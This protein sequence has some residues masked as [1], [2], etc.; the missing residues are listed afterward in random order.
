MFGHSKPIPFNPYGSRRARRRFPPWLALLVLGIAA[1]VGGVVFVQDR[2]L[3]PRLSAAESIRLRQAFTEADTER[4]RLRAELADTSKRLQVATA[5]RHSAQEALAANVAGSQ[6]LREDMAAAIAA[7]PPDP[8]GGTVQVRAGRFAAEGGGLSYDLI[9]TRERGGERALPAVL[10]LTVAGTTARGVESAVALKPVSLT[11]GAQEVT[12]GN[13][14][15]PDGFRPRQTTVAV[16]DRAGGR[17]L[18]MRVLLLK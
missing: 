16:L 14:P 9:L 11:I 10:Q 13:A 3:P 5:E 18:G 15:L 6:R 4:E 12:H 2:Y 17:S 1:G 8:R 7:L